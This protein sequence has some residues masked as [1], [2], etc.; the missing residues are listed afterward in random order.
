MVHTGHGTPSACP[1]TNHTIPKPTQTGPEASVREHRRPRNIPVPTQTTPKASFGKYRAGH[2]IHE[3]TQTADTL[4][5]TYASS[6][7]I[8][9]LLWLRPPRHSL[10]RAFGDDG[11]VSGR[12]RPQH[13]RHEMRCIQA[14]DEPY[15][16]TPIGPTSLPAAIRHTSYS[17]TP[18][19]RST[20]TQ[21]H[22][23]R[24]SWLEH[25]P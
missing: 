3:P 9:F 23:L 1:R 16:D 8:V 2:T 13:N 18:P 14:P 11:L 21:N 17:H 5:A 7:K 20:H 24:S 22:H 10:R 6:F 25:I 15:S 12:L 4:L 19:A